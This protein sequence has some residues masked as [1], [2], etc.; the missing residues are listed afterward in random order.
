MQYTS[1]STCVWLWIR[2]KERKQWYFREFKETRNATAMLQLWPKWGRASWLSTSGYILRNHIADP[3][4]LNLKDILVYVTVWKKQPFKC[5]HFKQLLIGPFWHVSC[6]NGLTDIELWIR[7]DVRRQRE[8]VC[9]RLCVYVY[10]LRMLCKHHLQCV[11]LDDV[12]QYW[13][14]NQKVLVLPGTAVLLN[15]EQQSHSLEANS[16]SVSYEISRHSCN[17]ES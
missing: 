10:I 14:S 13:L 7:D 17:S 8:S 6:V 15:T 5:D 12:L 4:F 16:R 11:R 3:N 2:E 9:V 1:I